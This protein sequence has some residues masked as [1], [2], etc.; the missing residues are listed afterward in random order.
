M[1][2]EEAQAQEATSEKKKSPIKL[3]AV[4]A[5]LMLI[6]GVAVFAV[7]SMTAPKAADAADLND[8][9][10]QPG[11]ALTEVELVKTRFQNLSTGRVWDWQT[12][13]YLK[14]REKNLEH[15]NEVLERRKAEIME[16]ISRIYRRAQH[17][18]LREPGL[19]S[20]S[21][22]VE[23]FVQEI[24]GNDPADD[25]PYVERVIIPKCDG[26]PSDF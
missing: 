23:A 15:V 1:P 4:I 11:E 20:I 13:I 17:A 25:T 26:Y 5:A 8:L 14:V 21:R 9:D 12:E 7:V 6:E 18:Q 3:I 22:Q 2:E 10:D 19:Q 24:F 16:G